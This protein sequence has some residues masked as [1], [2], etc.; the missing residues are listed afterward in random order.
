MNTKLVTFL[1]AFLLP[2]VR[3]AESSAN[4]C[5]NLPSCNSTTWPSTT[6]QHCNGTRQSPVNI[7]TK[8]VKLDLSL[9]PFSFSGFDDSSALL[10]ILNEGKT[11]KVFVNDSKVNV[12]KGGLADVYKTS[13]VHFHWGNGTFTGG[14]EHTLDGKQY[15]MEMHVVNYMSSY[16]SLDAALT[17]STGVAVLGFFIEASYGSGNPNSWKNLTSYLTKITNFGNSAIILGDF[18]LDSLLQGVN[19]SKY[20]RY[21]GSLTTPSCNEAVV[22]TVFKDSIKVSQDLINLFSTTVHTNTSSDPLIFNNFRISQ[23]LNGR[24]ITQSSLAT[25]PLHSTFISAVLLCAVLWWFC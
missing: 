23:N 13:Q 25:T 3:S 5:Y 12:S 1:I 8:N 14:S 19:R 4:W 21:L 18:T 7:E 16:G 22:W 9:V 20:Y 17:N 11:V 6:P 24:V 10:H 15:Q 2:T